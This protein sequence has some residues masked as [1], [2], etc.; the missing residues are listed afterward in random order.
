MLAKH[1]KRTFGSGE[2][3]AQRAVDSVPDLNR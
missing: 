3:V 2:I 1:S